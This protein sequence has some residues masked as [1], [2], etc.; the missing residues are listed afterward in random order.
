[1]RIVQD[2]FQELGIPL[3]PDKVVGPSPALTYLGIEIDADARIIRL[4]TEKLQELHRIL[5]TWSAHKKCT[6]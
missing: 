3:A 2:A 6:K 1:M 5:A 4:P